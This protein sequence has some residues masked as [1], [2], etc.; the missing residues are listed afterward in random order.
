MVQSFVVDQASVGLLQ[1]TVRVDRKGRGK[2]K[3]ENNVSPMDTMDDTPKRHK[4]KPI[5]PPTFPLDAATGCT[6]V[7]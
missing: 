7:G 6:S 5:D 2:R 3:D 1:Q 4:E